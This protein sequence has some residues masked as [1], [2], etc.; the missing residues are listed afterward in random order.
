MVLFT[1]EENGARGAL[2]YRDQ[3]RAE[4]SNHVVM[5]E[6]DGGVFRPIGFGFTGSDTARQTVRSIA[7]LLGD[8]GAD[9]IAGAGGGADIDPALRRRTFPPCRW[10]P[11]SRN[12]S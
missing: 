2:V 4:L 6:S 11:I 10:R 8:I 3:H 5:L 12:T 9:S 7:T 1:N